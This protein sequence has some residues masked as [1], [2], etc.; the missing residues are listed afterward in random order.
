MSTVIINGKELQSVEWCNEFVM[1]TETMSYFFVVSAKNIH[2]NFKNNESR[3]VEGKHFYKITGDDLKNLRSENFGLQISPMTRTLYLWTKRGTAR[4]AK[5]IN[6]DVAWDI[7]EM[8]EDA[9]FNRETAAEPNRFVTATAFER[10]KELKRLASHTR[11]P[12]TREK[13]VIEA[14]NLIAGREFILEN[15]FYEPEIFYAPKIH[16]RR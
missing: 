13:L 7:F 11:D 14:A 5:M 1:T 16:G 3:F 10:G 8:L 9:Y 12:L 6:S 2:D 4:H 15:P